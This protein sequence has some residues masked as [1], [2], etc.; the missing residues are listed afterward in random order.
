M[1]EPPLASGRRG[2]VFMVSAG[3]SFCRYFRH[4]GARGGFVDDGFAGGAGCEQG[5]DG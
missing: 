4:G 2:I 1:N 3:C 5:L